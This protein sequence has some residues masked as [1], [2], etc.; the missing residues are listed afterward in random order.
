MYGLMTASGAPILR[1]RLRGAAQGLGLDEL[2]PAVTL[3]RLPGAL[4]SCFWC[5]K[6]GQALGFP[7]SKNVAP[8][9]SAKPIVTASAA[10]RPQ[11]SIT[12]GMFTSGAAQRP[13]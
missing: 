10:G 6:S 3:R 1:H 13:A 4:Q 12:P 7:R 2:K 8:I 9:S 5:C 11:R